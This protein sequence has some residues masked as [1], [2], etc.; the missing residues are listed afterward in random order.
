MSASVDGGTGRSPQRRVYRR[1]SLSSTQARRGRRHDG[2]EVVVVG[3]VP[4][5]WLIR[6]NYEDWSLLM[7]VKMEARNLWDIVEFGDADH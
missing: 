6:S 4:F 1:R 5:P 7:R 2:P 3:G